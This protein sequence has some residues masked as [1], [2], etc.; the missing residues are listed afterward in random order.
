MRKFVLI[1]AALLGAR[2]PGSASALA[3]VP[4]EYNLPEDGRVSI[5]IRNDDGVVR[6]LLHAA[7]RKAGANVD[8]WDG[9]DEDGKPA[10]PGTYTWKLL[11]TQGL[12]AEYIVT[13]GLNPTPRWDSW[14]GNH[15][16][17]TSVAVDADAMYLAG[18]CS[19]GPPGL[20]KQDFDGKRVW[21]AMHLFDAW[22]GGHSSACAGGR[23]YLLQANGAIIVADT[24]TGRRI[25]R[26]DVQWDKDN[27]IK[28]SNGYV[29]F[30]DMD[31]HGDEIVVAYKARNAIRWLNPAD[32]SV[33]DEAEVPEPQGIAIDP[34]GGRVL[35]ASRDSILSLTRADKAPA[36]LVSGLTS[37]YRLDVEDATGEI[38]VYESGNSQQVKRFSP[39]GKLL[40]TYGAPG[41]RKDGPYDPMSFRTVHDITADQ[42]GGF[43]I[44]E[45][46]AAPRRTARFT[47]NGKLLND[48]FGGQMYANHGVA[49]PAD[50][51]LV[52]VDSQ[53]GEVMQ[54]KVDYAAKTWKVLATY[55]FG[56][57][58]DGFVRGTHHGGGRF[59]VLHHDGRT[60][61]CRQD[62]DPCVLMV[63]EKRGKLVPMVASDFS[64]AHDWD[65]PWTPELIRKL[66][67]PDAPNKN[68][69]Y[70][71]RGAPPAN[72]WMQA[73][74]WTDRNGDGKPQPPEIVWGSF[75][76]W[77]MGRWFTG[78]DFN[79]YRLFNDTIEVMRVFGW[80]QH[81]APIYGGWDFHEPIARWPKSIEYR[82]QHHTG[83]TLWVCPDGTIFACLNDT[84]RPFGTGFLSN[85]IG[86]N[87]VVKWN[88]DGSVAWVVGRHSATLGVEE[89]EARV[90]QRI[91]G[92]PHGCVVVGDLQCYYEVKNL[93]HV[94]DQDGLWVGRML[95]SP[96]LNAAPESAYVLCT[97]NFGGSLYE[98]KPDDDLPGLNAGDVIFFGSGQ[99]G[100]PVYRVTGWD[101]FRRQSGTLVLTAEAAAKLTARI[102]AERKRP[103]LAHIKPIPVR[104][105]GAP[106][107]DG[108]LA[109]WEGF[110]PL[111]ITDGKTEVAKL[112]LGWN[113]NGIY[114]AFDVMKDRPWKSA[115]SEREPFTNGAA[116]DL[117]IGPLQPT[118][119]QA[120]PG[121]ARFV[122]APVGK[123]GQTLLIEMLPYLAPGMP[124]TSRKPQTYET[125]QGKITFQ[126]VAPLP[127]D[128]VAA[129]SK[130]DGG[131][132]VELC[133]PL[134]APLL[135]KPGRRFRFDA[136]V[137]LATPAGDHSEGRLL[138]HSTA[139]ADQ[140]VEADRY[141]EAVLRPAN[142]GEAVLE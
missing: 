63:D 93:V 45:G 28:D 137:I 106:K 130:E 5:I 2:L 125:G 21:T 73:Y 74:H 133:V 23:L 135:C 78:E 142:W 68:P 43:F 97:E 29:S 47:R 55:R 20:I 11:L 88:P 119:E 37:P 66:V 22:Q 122:A 7:R 77:Y 8:T 53:F 17:V 120:A 129:K 121:D 87:H 19:E 90:F 80:T 82:M 1:L 94:W 85:E 104:G 14:P 6:E 89:G 92:A 59:R 126:R 140:I 61:L 38:Y 33:V 79:Y 136:S 127:A 102:E 15:N 54:C 101:K 99:N 18:G 65:Q 42:R 100:T 56:G 30:M 118:R 107:L 132:V 105:R 71:M 128:H 34:H 10:K 123:N 139:S 3:E 83:K 64:V 75:K 138:W 44:C 35:V 91:I 49:D 58:A 98:V 9:L 31:A 112:Y 4:I 24:D 36:V 13:L 69:S 32:G 57:L 70:D 41:G 12:K 115:A 114:A 62:D 110:Q 111:T 108:D 96:D 103:D 16:G 67:N 81:G 141:Y 76:G 131:Y 48:W 60:Y 84:T 52:W 113:P 46:W 124:E 40:K 95:E 117:M 51:T 72:R 39:D 25:A 116:V 27:P 134:R 86:D 50:P 26:W 109:E